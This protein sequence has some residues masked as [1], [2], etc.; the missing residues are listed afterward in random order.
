M[1]TPVPHP[2]FGADARALRTPLLGSWIHAIEQGDGDPLV[3]LHGNPTSSFLWRHVF[4]Q[5]R[6]HGRLLAPDLVGYGHSGKPSID[7]TLPEQQHYLDAWFDALGLRDV[8]LVLQDYGAAFGLNWASRH[9]GRVRG[10]V[11]MEPVLRDPGATQPPALP[12]ELLA[13]RA[14][15]REPG[16]GEALVLEQNRFLTELFPHLFLRPPAPEDMV[17]YLAPF[18]DAASRRPILAA[19][20]NLPMQGVPASSVAFLDQA[21]AWLQSSATP[22]LLLTFEPGWLLTPQ[23][24][25][26]SRTHLRKLQVQAV[27]AGVHFV[28]EDQPDAI[29]RHIA[30]WLASIAETTHAATR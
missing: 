25:D 23:T 28:Q 5:L 12:A 9:P 16:T 18:P 29:A 3:F 15:M 10:V 27:G 8:V 13:L 4:R 24:L 6:G 22:K 30:T 11:L 21:T 2:A 26:W 14:A 1:S 17:H 20:R 19:R 7:Y